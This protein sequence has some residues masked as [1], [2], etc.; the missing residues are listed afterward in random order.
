[1]TTTLEHVLS[2]NDP[3]ELRPQLTS[4]DPDRAGERQ[5]VRYLVIGPAGAV[6]FVYWRLTGEAYTREKEMTAKY[7]PNESSQDDCDGGYLYAVDLGYHAR[8][9]MAYQRDFPSRECEY[10]GRCWYDGSS[11]NA[12]PVLTRLMK[13][14]PDAVWRYLEDYYRRIFETPE[15]EQTLG[16]VGFGRVLHALTGGAGEGR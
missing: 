4:D 2:T 1:M 6:Q 15:D 14:G 3:R 12:A 5:T 9:P 16:E 10:V 7:G 13:R 8:A 11:L